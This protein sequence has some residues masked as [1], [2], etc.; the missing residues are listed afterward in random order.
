MLRMKAKH[1]KC[2]RPG[3]FRKAE[4]E[5]KMW[6]EITIAAYIFVFIVKKM[7]IKNSYKKLKI[8]FN[9]QLDN[10]RSLMALYRSPEFKSS[11]VYKLNTW[12]IKGKLN[13]RFR[14]KH[15]EVSALLYW[16]IC[17]CEI[18][19]HQIVSVCFINCT[20]SSKFGGDSER[21]SKRT[22]Q[23]NYFEIRLGQ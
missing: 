5:G 9:W 12:R 10:R 20:Q 16:E 13:S 6:K 7:N 3:G 17:K 23:R 14:Q 11:Q 2:W 19:F 21:F 15:F 18:K 22:F 4:E 1:W 8:L